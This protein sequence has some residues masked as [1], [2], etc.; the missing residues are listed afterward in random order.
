MNL[1]DVKNVSLNYGYNDILKGVNFQINSGNRYGL[2]GKNGSG[3]TSLL[4]ILTEE[5]EDFE[6]S[7][8]YSKGLKI[9]Y[10]NQY[11]SFSDDLSVFD[12]LCLEYKPSINNLVELEIKLAESAENEYKR[13]LPDF[14]EAS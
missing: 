6:G 1:L 2:I 5:L 9:G 13:I 3:K 12:A 4:N 8:T 10:V 14:F 11:I 7:I